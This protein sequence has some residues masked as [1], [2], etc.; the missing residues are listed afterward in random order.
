[1]GELFRKIDSEIIE[2]T[3]TERLWGL[4]IELQNS[5]LQIMGISFDELIIMM[6]SNDQVESKI[7]EMLTN[8]KN[9]SQHQSY[10]NTMQTS[11]YQHLI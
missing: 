1:M 10:E 2:I 8:M 11:V 7:V 5:I 9:W 3:L 4:F 6:L